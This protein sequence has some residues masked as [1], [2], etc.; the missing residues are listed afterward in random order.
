MKHVLLALAFVLAQFALAGPAHA[1]TTSAVAV[2]ACGTPPNSPVAGNAYPV[3]QDLT[4]KLCTSGATGGPQISVG[5][6]NAGSADT[7]TAPVKIGCIFVS[8][9]PTLT[10]TWIGNAQCDSG[11]RLLAHLVG[12]SLALS[13]GQSNTSGKLDIGGGAFAGL[14]VTGFAFNGSTWD[15]IRSI[16]GAISAAGVGVTAV[17]E[18][19]RLFNHISTLTTT[20]VKSGAGFLHTVTINTKGASA[21]VITVYDSLTASGTVIGVIDGTAG[22]VTFTYDAAFSIGLTFLT[23]TG[24]AADITVTYR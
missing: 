12:T 10:T 1:D 24:T 22:P 11:G 14:D 15:R 23:A 18:T 7:G 4:G 16:Q 9:P 6:T 5:P 8:T 21:N 13:D 19:G 17:E 3:T 2:S 20:T